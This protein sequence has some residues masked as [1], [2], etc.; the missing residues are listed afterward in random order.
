MAD[1]I[2]AACPRSVDAAASGLALA[3]TDRAELRHHRPVWTVDA[4]AASILDLIR[5]SIQDSTLAGAVRDSVPAV[6]AL[7]RASEDSDRA[8]C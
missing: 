1:D 4:M 6:S 2:A 8:G 7:V 3:D 5:D